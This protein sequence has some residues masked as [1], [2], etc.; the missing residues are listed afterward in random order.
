[1]S[2]D[3]VSLVQSEEASADGNESCAGVVCMGDGLP[4]RQGRRGG[5]LSWP[6]TGETGPQIMSSSPDDITQARFDF[7]TKRIQGLQEELRTTRERFAHCHRR[8]SLIPRKLWYLIAVQSVR[9]FATS[10]FGWPWAGVL[11]GAT[12]VGAIFCAVTLSWIAALYGVVLGTVVFSGLLYLP[13]N[14]RLVA[15]IQELQSDKTW[16]DNERG[17][18][19]LQLSRITSDLCSVEK[20]RCHVGELL[21]EKQYRESQKYRRQQLLHKDWRALRGVPFEEF[22]QEVFTELQ[23]TVKRTPT[24]GD[25]GADLILSKDGHEI[26][27]QAKGYDGSVGNDAVRDAYAGMGYHKCGACAV[28]TN[29]LFTSRAKDAANRLRCVLIDKNSLP[30]LITGEIDVRQLAPQVPMPPAIPVRVRSGTSRPISRRATSPKA[31]LRF[32]PHLPNPFRN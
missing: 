29:S 10:V 6:G 14:S 22:L 20:Y 30:G 18:I 12:A 25:H 5:R 1:M 13:G 27:I 24:T 8:Q 4:A 11:I 15:N 9:Q 16:F 23:Y 2:P 31:S 32:H 26:V 3:P 7:L 21:A 19:S 17:A 28:V